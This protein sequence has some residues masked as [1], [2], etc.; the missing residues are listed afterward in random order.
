MPMNASGTMPKN[1]QK[2][3]QFG[4]EINGFDAA[5]FTKGKFPSVE[6]D[7]SEFNA[8][9]SGFPQKSHGRAKFENLTFEKGIL[10]DGADTAALD[11]L[12]KHMDFETGTGATTEAVMRDLDL[13]G[14]DVAGREFRRFTL[15][16]AFIQKYEGDD[17]EGGSSEHA[18]EKLSLCYQYFTKK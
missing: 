5:L 8:A 4:I 2:K 17:Y 16:G 11:W 10:V 14:Y 13:I 6:F 7:V 18:V 3:Y 1:V 9:G 12:T 15:H